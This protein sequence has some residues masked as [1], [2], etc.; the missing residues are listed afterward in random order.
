MYT[1][2]NFDPD[3]TPYLV[4]VCDQDIM[5]PGQVR[6]FPDAG[7]ACDWIEKVTDETTVKAVRAWKIQRW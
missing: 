7:T 3:K 4:Q 1:I 6:A 2:W 5:P